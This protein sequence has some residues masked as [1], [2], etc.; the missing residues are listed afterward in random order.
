MY[1]DNNMYSYLKW[2]GDID[3]AKA[4]FNEIDALVL[5]IF[6]YLNLPNIVS[7]GPK[8]ITVQEAAKIY[9]SPNYYRSDHSYYQKLFKLMSEANRFKNAKLSYYVNTLTDQTQFSAIKIQLTNGINFIAFRGTDDSLVGWKEDFEISFKTTI[10]QEQAVRYLTTIMNHDNENY[11]LGG[12]SKGGNLAEYAALNV[13]ADL[14]KRITRIY[15]FDSPGIA[16]EVGNQIPDDYL[17]KTLHRYVPEFSIIGRLFEPDGITATIV[18]S[19]RKTLSQHDAFSWEVTGS[20]FVTRRHRNPQAKIYNQIISEWIGD[21]SLEEREAL[22]NDLF[23]AFAASG[24]T[25]INE[26][27]KNGFGGF[28][29]ILISLANSSRKTRFVVGSLFTTLW[30]TIKNMEIIKALFTRDTIVGWVMVILGIVSLTAPQY[31][32]RA[33]GALVAF[34]GIGFSVQQILKTANTA[35]QKKQKQSFIIS[36]LLIFALSIALLSNN[37]LLIFL[38]H[39]FLGIFLVVYSYI[40]LRQV[41]LRAVVGVFQKIIVCI[42]AIIAFALGIIVVVNPKYFNKES[43]IIV[44]ILLIIYGFFKLVDELFKQRKKLPTKHR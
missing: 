28:G 34:A 39:Y 5:S 17:K 40:R 7:D 25:K 19:S 18:E 1:P 30:Q 43:I 27:S 10:A 14:R 2:R 6:S 21:A 29:A 36:Y 12:H 8:T 15:T 38:A 9:F 33:F 11:M 44:G 4:P 42:E 16:Q 37:R 24:A 20:H 26:L 23:G 41:I 3:L 22:T 32:I 31:A 13:S 35:L